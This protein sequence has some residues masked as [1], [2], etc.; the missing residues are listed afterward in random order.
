MLPRDLARDG[1]TYMLLADAA[2]GVPFKG[3]EAD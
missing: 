3:I 1:E 2:V